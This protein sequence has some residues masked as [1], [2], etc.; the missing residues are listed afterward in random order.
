MGRRVAGKWKGKVNRVESEAGQAESVQKAQKLAQEKQLRLLQKRK[1]AE[2]AAKLRKERMEGKGKKDKVDP[3]KVAR[4][5]AG[6]Q[7]G[8]LI[9]MFWSAWQI[10]V[11]MGK[12]LKALEKRGTFWQKSCVM[13][14]RCMGGC[15]CCNLLRETVFQM[16]Y[17]VQRSAGGGFLHPAPGSR[18]NSNTGLARIGSAGFSLPDRAPSRDASS[19][20]LPP[21]AQRTT[22]PQMGM[23]HDR[24]AP[25]PLGQSRSEPTLRLSTPPHEKG[26]R[27]GGPSSR[28]SHLPPMMPGGTW[29]EATHWRT[30]AACWYNS[31][32]GQMSLIPPEM[33]G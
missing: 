19:L 9:K 28:F 30:G 6:G 25:T 11:Q 3:M 20:V 10:A 13:D 27:P 16:P 1:A 21:I 33:M 24:R 29:E 2:M 8:A 15:S 4:M 18:G 22:T 23:G 7:S 31:F 32:T 17:Q 12:D 26:F 5:L 14:R